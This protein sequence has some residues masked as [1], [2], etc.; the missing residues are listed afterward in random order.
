MPNS[1]ARS[2]KGVF[3]F[4]LLKGAL[5][6]FPSAGFRMIC[7]YSPVEPVVRERGHGALRNVPL[8]RS[9]SVG[10]YEVSVRNVSGVVS[11]VTT[12]RG[13]EDGA[14]HPCAKS[15]WRNTQYSVGG[16]LV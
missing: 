5:D 15:L 3:S 11:C 12:W 14:G 2:S 13:R 1:S 9:L 7:W 10:L 4:S 6:Y 8:F 16:S